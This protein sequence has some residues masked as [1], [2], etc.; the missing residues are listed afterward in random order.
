MKN[1]PVRR[2]RSRSM[3]AGLGAG[4]L[5]VAGFARAEWAGPRR[6]YAGFLVMQPGGRARV[7]ARLTLQGAGGG[8]VAVVLTLPERQYTG[9]GMVAADG[10]ARLTPCAGSECFDMRG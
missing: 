6:N 2:F 7:P 1:V 5:T 4:L 8:R 3:A 10:R 9:P